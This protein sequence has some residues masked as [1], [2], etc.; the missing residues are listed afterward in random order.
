MCFLFLF[1]PNPPVFR[2]LGIEIL[3]VDFLHNLVPVQSP[4]VGGETAGGAIHTQRRKIL[5]DVSH[6]AQEYKNKNT[7][8]MNGCLFIR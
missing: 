8:K 2:L 1:I 7:N 3:R 5:A 4:Q 6:V